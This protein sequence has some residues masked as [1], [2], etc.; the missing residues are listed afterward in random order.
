MTQKEITVNNNLAVHVGLTDKFSPDVRAMLMAK[1][2]RDISSIA[3]RLPEG[4]TDME[5]HRKALHK[6]YVGYGHKSIAQC[7]TTD[8]FIE[9]VSMLAAKA[10]ENN[11]LFNGQE[12]STRYIDMSSQPMVSPTI[13]IFQWQENFRELYVK[14]L[15]ATKE[16]L[17][18]EFPFDQQ[19]EGT[20]QEVWENTINARAFDIC[21]G[22]L[23]AGMTTNVG[24]SATFDTINEHF[25]QMFRHPS[26]E[27]S[28]VAASVLHGIRNTYPEVAFDIKKSLSR[29]EHVTDHYFY[30]PVPTD[31][32]SKA[33]VVPAGEEFY[34]NAWA[35]TKNNTE[36][37]LRRAKFTDIDRYTSSQMR[38]TMYGMLDFG[39]Y[40]DLHRHR[41]GFITMPVLTPNNGMHPYYVDMLPQNIAIE[42]LQ[43]IEKYQDW[44]NS[45]QNEHTAVQ[46]QYS[47]PMGCMVAFSYECDIN[48]AI[49][50]ME[51]RSA[52][53]VHQTLRQLVIHWAR[54][55]HY[56]TNIDIHIDADE[57]NFTLK[58]GEQTFLK[59]SF[60]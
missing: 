19:E 26:L 2:S 9:G 4:D 52:K 43:A 40:R 24:M 35:I 12:C 32:G 23:P 44:Y 30:Q 60:T 38:M 57:D 36:N 25:S 37:Y 33:N 27:M 54:Q 13:E 29:Y 18:E 15:A 21:R 49:Y 31:L 17:K 3:T 39:S 11:P 7:A 16:K 8:I 48:Q 5:Q 51:L 42:L 55:L 46:K 47:T 59:D 28:Q 20:K 1:Y 10:I 53:T 56:F 14:A 45:S 34:R 58:R 22:I 41:N 50:I 6:Y